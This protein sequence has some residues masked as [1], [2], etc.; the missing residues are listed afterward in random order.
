[1]LDTKE[2]QRYEQLRKLGQELHIPI[3]EAFLTL[4]VFGKNGKLLLRHHQRSHSWVRN[5]YNIMFSYLAGKDLDQASFG[6]GLLSLK[7]TAAAVCFGSGTILQSDDSLDTVGPVECGYRSP[8]EEDRWGIMVGSGTDAESFEDYKLQTQIASGA[9]A[10]QLNHIASQPHAID[11]SAPVLK[12]ELARYFNNNSGG[13]VNVN[14]VALCFKG[15][16]PGDGLYKWYVT[17][18]DKLP[19]IVTVPDTG[20]LKVTYTV[21]LTYPA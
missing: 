1:M 18:R 10:G 2:E 5:A 3:P 4:E 9:A 15:Y 11:W 20:Q 21:Q 17:S 8:A 19:G 7:D 13:A 14:E 12:N 6:A 16:Q